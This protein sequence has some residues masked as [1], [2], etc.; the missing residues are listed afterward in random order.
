MSS[1]H[2]KS[3]ALFSLMN[4]VHN[5]ILGYSSHWTRPDTFT[6]HYPRKE[7]NQQSREGNSH[8]VSITLMFTRF[9]SPTSSTPYH[10]EGYSRL[11]SS[12]HHSSSWIEP[13][14]STPPAEMLKKDI[15]PDV[16]KNADTWLCSK[17]SL[18]KD[19][20]I[21]LLI[22]SSPSWYKSRKN[23]LRPA[24]PSNCSSFSWYFKRVKIRNPCRWTA[25]V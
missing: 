17:W 8:R 19:F 21:A 15:K 24:S 1:L 14:H 25:V 3:Q 22:S 9:S 18:T 6:K 13:F 11:S 5:T 12:Q 7:S 2:L 10:Q 23:L 20:C 4:V 16:S